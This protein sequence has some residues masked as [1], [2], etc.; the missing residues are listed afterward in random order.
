M[1]DVDWASMA[2]LLEMSPIGRNDFEKYYLN[3]WDPPPTPTPRY[4][5]DPYET[6]ALEHANQ[7][8]TQHGGVLLGELPPGAPNTSGDCP[9]AEALK[10]I[11]APRNMRVSVKTEATTIGRSF[12]VIR[13]DEILR[14]FIKRFD[15]A[16]YYHLIK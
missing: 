9:L 3:A 4:R 11:F 5:M 10:P 12:L 7:I 2:A 15:R 13:H 8:R 6:R 1:K 14:E 16:H